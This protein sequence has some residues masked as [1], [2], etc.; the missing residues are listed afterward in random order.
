MRRRAQEQ[1]RKMSRLAKKK[2]RNSTE[3]FRKAFEMAGK[4]PASAYSKRA[5]TALQSHLENSHGKGLRRTLYRL[6]DMP[7][8]SRSSVVVFIFLVG[9]IFASV[10]SFFLATV[11]SLKRDYSDELAILDTVIMAIFSFELVLRVI[12]ATLD[13][14]RMLICDACE[15]KTPLGSAPFSYLSQTRAPSRIAPHPR[16]TFAPTYHRRVPVC[17][18]PRVRARLPP[19]RAP[20][21]WVDVIVLV[22]SYLSLGGVS[23]EALPAFFEVLQ[24]LRLLR[25][26]KLMR[27]YSG[28]QVLIIALQNSWRAMLV[29]GFAMLITTMMLSGLLFLVE[30]GPNDGS[31][32]DAFPDAFGAMWCIFWIVATLGFDGSMG[33]GG[34]AGQCIIGIAIISG[35]IFTTMP[36]VRAHSSNHAVSLPLLASLAPCATPA[37]AWASLSTRPCPPA[38]FAT[39]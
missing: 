25:T 20:D 15:P 38:W 5:N 7:G 27:M 19:S 13:L 34:Q 28:W 35:L 1:V 30:S 21:F 39:H 26:L 6:L 36:I 24:L 32:P 18:D 31:D 2:G 10:L 14:Q 3:S 33:T 29:P 11:P 16:T 9:T 23:F 8:S 4:L 12:V 17:P 37:G 22:P